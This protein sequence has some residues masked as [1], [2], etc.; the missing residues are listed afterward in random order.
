VNCTEP[1][2]FIDAVG[3]YIETESEGLPHAKS[4]VP[5]NN[6]ETTT[7]ASKDV[8]KIDFANAQPPN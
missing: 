2:T 6:D 8:A 1:P 5:A 4:V 3:G 7:T